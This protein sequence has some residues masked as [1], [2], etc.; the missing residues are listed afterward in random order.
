MFTNLLFAAT[1]TCHTPVAMVAVAEPGQRWTTMRYGAGSCDVSLDSPLFS[2]VGRGGE[3]LEIVDLR[4]HP[5]LGHTPLATG[6]SAIRYVYGLPLRAPGAPLLGV[7]CVLD[8]RSRQMSARERLGLAAIASKVAGHLAVDR[9][10]GVRRHPNPPVGEHGGGGC[11]VHAP[12]AVSP[13]VGPEVNLP[14]M[15]GTKEVAA[16][17][18]VTPRTALNWAVSNRL[19]SVRTPGG[20]VR[21]HRDEVLAK[22]RSSQRG[23]RSRNTPEGGGSD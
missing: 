4:L 11:R 19:S 20:Q 7:L 18:D 23:S 1:L 14:P 10:L 12:V 9:R 2:L 8:R 15:L 5:Q 3:P 17:F 22:L 21:F 6:P 13:I 16:L